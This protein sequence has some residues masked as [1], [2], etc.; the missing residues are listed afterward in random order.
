MP[1][2]FK[3]GR[4]VK[5]S[6]YGKIFLQYIERAIDEIDSGVTEMQKIANPNIGKV[7]IS[8]VSS[9]STHF[10]PDII[11][12]FYKNPDNI[13]IKFELNENQTMYTLEKIQEKKVDIGFGTKIQNTQMEYFPIK[14]EELFVVVSKDHRWSKRDSI[15]VEEL[16][17]CNLV[18]YSKNCGTRISVDNLLKAHSVNANIVSEVEN[19]TMVASLVSSNYMFWPENEYMLPAAKNFRDYIID[20]QQGNII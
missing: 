16:E 1:L 5:L 10:I 18:T 9:L 17:G 4:N 3:N 20:M 13:N 6:K 2:F 15:Q 19:D 12:K 8:F 11:K 7:S 14:K